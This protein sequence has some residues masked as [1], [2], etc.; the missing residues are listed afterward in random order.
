MI[1]WSHSKPTLT[2]SPAGAWGGA[3]P[4]GLPSAFQ[5]L[6]IAWLMELFHPLVHASPQFSLVARWAE[7]D[8]MPVQTQPQKSRG[9]NL[10]A[11][12][13]SRSAIHHV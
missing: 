10:G 1:P 5:V 6:S 9:G 7:H 8:P 4:I 12:D 3:E 11:P 2:N 13:A